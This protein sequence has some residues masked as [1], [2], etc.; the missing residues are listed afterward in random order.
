MN[1]YEPVMAIVDGLEQETKDTFLLR[2]SC[3][4]LHDPGQFMIIGLPGYG[5]APISICSYS[6]DYLELCFKVV[7]AVTTALSKLGQGDEVYIRGPYGRGYPMKE[8]EGKEVVLIGGGTGVAPMRSIIQY[9]DRNMEKYKK[10]RLFF[11][12]RTFDDILFKADFDSW[13]LAFDFNIS[14]DTPD[15]RWHG[16]AGFVTNL[17]KDAGISKDSV[18]V[19]CGPPIMLKLIV[20]LLHERG[21]EDAQIYMS[22]E[23]L[24]YCGIGKCGHCLVNG[25]YVCKSGPVFRYD[26][27]KEII[28]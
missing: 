16:Y 13:K 3:H 19:I 24:M 28:D 12:F 7:G 6:D 23:R 27:G 14:L 25:R 10:A 15:P 17:V 5:E 4:I 2:I 11:G 8:L 26:R 18:V 9:I 21:V 20:P 1:P 22:I